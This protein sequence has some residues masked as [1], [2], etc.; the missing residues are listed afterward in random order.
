MTIP[1]VDKIA[2]TGKN[3]RNVCFKK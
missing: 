3:V 1:S 2:E